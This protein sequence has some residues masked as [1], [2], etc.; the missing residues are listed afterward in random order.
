[1]LTPSPYREQHDGYLGRY[2]ATGECRIIGMAARVIAGGCTFML[3]KTK[4]LHAT[5]N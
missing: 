3:V 4:K 1:M 2:L 5:A